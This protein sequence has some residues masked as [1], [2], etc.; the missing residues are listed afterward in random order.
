MTAPGWEALRQ[1]PRGWSIENDEVAEEALAAVEALG[2]IFAEIALHRLSRLQLDPGDH[3]LDL[4]LRALGHVA[5]SVAMSRLTWQTGIDEHGQ[6][7]QDWAGTQ[8]ALAAGQR[9]RAVLSWLFEWDLT[10]PKAPP[11]LQKPSVP[12]PSVRLALD[13]LWAAVVYYNRRASAQGTVGP[14]RRR[15][16]TRASTRK[17]R[18]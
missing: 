12:P 10:D 13:E 17:D 7:R 15:S 5:G 14:G 11:S 18:S 8:E 3:D 4:A 2:M 6:R 9:M 16:I 1:D